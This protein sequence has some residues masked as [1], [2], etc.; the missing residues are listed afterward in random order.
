MRVWLDDLRDMPFDFDHH[1]RTAAEA[2]QLLAT[3][4]VQRI[5]LD[6]DLGDEG[7]GTGYEVAKWIEAKAFAWSQGDE[8][9]LPPLEWSI[10][11][12][13]P[14]GLKNITQALRNAD[15][16]WAM[17]RSQEDRQQQAE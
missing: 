7:N 11:S 4:A 17:R 5:S 13:N 8:N 12:Q 15:R 1:A 10:H 9:G 14:V 3:G 16:F 6:H 2:I